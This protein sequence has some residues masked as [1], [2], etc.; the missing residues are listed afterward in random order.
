MIGKALRE[1]RALLGLAFEIGQI[2]FLRKGLA[3]PAEVPS[4]LNAQPSVS[5]V[6]RVPERAVSMVARAPAAS[7]G[8]R[9]EDELLDGSIE[10]RRSRSK[11]E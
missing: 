6:V 2:L 3:K 9:A 5:P 10:A 8:T 7:G 11:W 1:G 4:K